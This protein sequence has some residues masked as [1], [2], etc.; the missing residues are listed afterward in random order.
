MNI[1]QLDK[2]IEK[3]MGIRIEDVLADEKMLNVFRDCNGYLFKKVFP[4]FELMLDK[5]LD[6]LKTENFHEKL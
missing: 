1:K 3:R 5:K 6:W 4:K 2:Y